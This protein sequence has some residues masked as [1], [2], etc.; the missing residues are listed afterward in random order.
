LRSRFDVVMCDL[1]CGPAGRG[2]VQSDRVVGLD[3]ILLAV[4]P[5]RGA[6]EA[7]ARFVDQFGDAGLRGD[8]GRSVRL[9]VVTTTDEG[10]TEL[11]PEV[12]AAMLGE[13]VLASVPQRWGRAVPNVGF[14]AALGIDEL[15]DAVWLLWQRLRTAATA[16]SSR[17]S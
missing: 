9:G 16:L 7:A 6:V 3:W 5:E 10:S 12:V 17:A 13:T 4:T 15:D 1:A 2:V 8:R 11:S 14:G